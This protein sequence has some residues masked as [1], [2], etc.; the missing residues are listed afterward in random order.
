VLLLTNFYAFFSYIKQHITLKMSFS[1]VSE[2]LARIRAVAPVKKVKMAE[3]CEALSEFVQSCTTKM[4]NY[5]QTFYI[6]FAIDINSVDNWNV[7]VKNTILEVN[8]KNEEEFPNVRYAVDVWN[9]STPCTRQTLGETAPIFT[10]EH[11]PW[12]T[13]KVEEKCYVV[14][15]KAACDIPSDKHSAFWD[16]YSVSDNFIVNDSKYNDTDLECAFKDEKEAS[17]AFTLLMKESNEDLYPD[18][19][20]TRFTDVSISEEWM[21]IKEKKEKDEESE[22]EKSETEESENEEGEKEKEEKDASS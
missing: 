8:K 4:T 15:A 7:V 5:S 2:T 19:E 13:L 6:P 22:D 1:P 10:C 14:K 11:R 12:L 18:S 3:T 21:E 17:A 16:H 20:I 9:G